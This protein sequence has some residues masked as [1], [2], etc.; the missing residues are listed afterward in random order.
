MT[1]INKEQLDDFA[2]GFYWAYRKAQ[3][4]NTHA[5]MKP[6]VILHNNLG[7]L[8]IHILESRKDLGRMETYDIL[9]AYVEVLKEVEEVYDA[10]RTDFEAICNS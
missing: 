2:Q 6:E 5:L 1:A 3:E 4:E 8:A 10:N 7:L 9:K